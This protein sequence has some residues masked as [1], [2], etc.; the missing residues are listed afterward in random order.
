MRM[1]ASWLW[2]VWRRSLSQRRRPHA[3]VVVSPPFLG[4]VL[5]L[6]L[7][8]RLRAPVVYHVQD[9]QVDAALRLGMLPPVLA[10]MLRWIERFVLARVD[11][12]S[13][14]SAEMRRRLQ[15][16]TRT[17]RPVVLFPNWADTATVRPW[18]GD[19]R[20]RRDWGVADDRPVVMYSGNLGQKQGVSTLLEAAALC[21]LDLLLVVAG[22][23][24]ERA[25]LEAHAARLGLR[26]V[27]FIGLAAK[28]RLSE[29]LSAADLHCIPQRREAAGLVMPSKLLNIMAVARAVVVTADPGTD[30]AR[31]I[32]E[33]ACGLVAAPDAA[34]PL[35]EAIDI[36]LGDP[37]R[38]QRQGRAGRDY[39]E[40]TLGIDEVVGGFA[41]Q[42]VR[43]VRSTAPSLGRA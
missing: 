2:Q 9:L 18:H 6:L 34:Q 41:D 33:A 32:E 17:L 22:E 31:A 42:L 29:F 40:R 4:G 19:N 14:I 27:R 7:R 24:S 21:R 3:I 5:G 28:E 43:L 20:F 23:G 37:E 15:A 13:T 26:K 30:L 35:A 16:K 8:A 39:V 36:L 11:L 1:D 38:R 10:G 25:Q 12:V